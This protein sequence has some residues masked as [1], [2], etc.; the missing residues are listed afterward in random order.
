MTPALA[1]FLGFVLLTLV[2]TYWSA[3]RSQGAA[4]TSPPAAASPAGKTASPWR[5]IT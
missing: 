3:R 4:H 2:I 1:M 5:A